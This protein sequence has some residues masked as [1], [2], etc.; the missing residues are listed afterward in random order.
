M[1]KTLKEFIE[2]FD[3]VAETNE[4]LALFQALRYFHDKIADYWVN[5][6]YS[7]FHKGFRQIDVTDSGTVDS[8]IWHLMACRNTD[9][10]WN[11]L[12]KYK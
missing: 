7:Y 11:T 8:M 1:K 6:E 4:E 5:A 3:K 9:N 2:D 10:F 12:A